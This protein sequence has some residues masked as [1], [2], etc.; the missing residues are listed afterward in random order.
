[1]TTDLELKRTISA[2]NR[3]L[4]VIIM[5]IITEAFPY[6]VYRVRKTQK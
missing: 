4:G 6:R 3:D 1:M 5:Q 2:R